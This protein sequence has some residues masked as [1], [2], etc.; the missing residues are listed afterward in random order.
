MHAV[1]RTPSSEFINRLVDAWPDNGHLVMSARVADGFDRINDHLTRQQAA[2]LSAADLSFTPDEVKLLAHERRSLELTDTDARQLVETMDGWPLGVSLV[3][4]SP[5][6]FNALNTSGRNQVFDFLTRQVLVQ[7]P[8]AAQKLLM[9]LS[10]FTVI[11]P[12][13]CAEVLETANLRKK[14]RKLVDN[15]LFITEAGPDNYQYHQLFREFLQTSLK[16]T[17]SELFY[18]LHGKAAAKYEALGQY[19]PAI[20]HFLT[21]RNY[22]AAAA[23]IRRIGE[24]LFRQGRWTSLNSWIERL[25]ESI[26]TSSVDIEL[27]HAQSLV[28]TGEPSQAGQIITTILL[29]DT[30]PLDKVTK[31]RAL[32]TRSSACRLLGQRDQSRLDA[33]VAA[34]LLEGNDSQNGLMGD[35]SARLGFLHFDKA[36]FALAMRYLKTA[37]EQFNKVFDQNNL[38]SV[39]NGLGGIYK[40]F[41]NLSQASTYYEYARQGFTKT[42]NIGKLAMV[43]CNIAF[44]QHKNG[45][46]EQTID[47]LNEAEEKAKT[48]GYRRFEANIALAFGEVYR[49]L[50]QPDRSISS[51]EKAL[52]I[53]REIQEANYVSY[54]KAGIGETLRIVGNYD[55]ANFWTREALAQAE[56]E[57]QPY[58]I[59][60]FKLQLATIN[61]NQCKYH[62]ASM[63]LNEVYKYFLKI[64]D[65]DALART[66]FANAIASFNQKNYDATNQW[67]TWM[68]G[69][70]ENLGYDDFVVIEGGRNTLLVQYA[71]ARDIGNRYF[72][73]LMERIKQKRQQFSTVREKTAVPVRLTQLQS[74][75]FNETRVILDGQAVT[76]QAWRSNRAKELFFF[77][78][79]N[80]GKSTEDIAS[81]LW[82]EMPPAKATSNFHIN[83]FRAR[84]ATSPGIIIQENGRYY[85]S[86][87]VDFYYD[88]NE[89]EEKLRGISQLAPEERSRIVERLTELYKGSFMPGFDGEWIDQKRFELENK[90][91]KLLFEMVGYYAKS[92]RMDKV[93]ALVEKVLDTDRDDDEVYYQGIQAYLALGDSLSA[94]H[95]YK[96]YLS[97]LKELDAEPEPRIEN[98]IGNLSIN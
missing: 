93:V 22:D 21:A 32:Y 33:E 1:A 31:A 55:Q 19:E 63:A 11:E 82:P 29:D 96:R 28:H 24:K 79:N 85:F 25:P 3:L 71:A 10:T 8:A 5:N 52:T 86:P 58:E 94:S 56:L 80:P 70:I 76:E 62:E 4:N 90:Y 37:Q 69:H 6:G 54:A 50:D 17:D 36:D 68:I 60:L 74:F 14:L 48:A 15:S 72:E 89:F 87:E 42:G 65:L 57:K 73:R 27:L 46:Y 13:L 61:N 26:R 40:S 41:G 39:N 38:A 16:E 30:R 23:L 66:C 78:L 75:G 88:V 49:D 44:I 84:R 35:I 45:L 53:A 12:D 83:L 43:L 20:E 34:G 98:L 51:F 59:S 81:Q 91:L 7:Q 2:C 67:L 64:G 95:L 9:G 18:G 77:L 92:G 97:N 47:T